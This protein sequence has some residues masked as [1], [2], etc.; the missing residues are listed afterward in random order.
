M[1]AMVGYGLAILAAGVLMGALVRVPSLVIA[2]TF[3][4]PAGIT[5]GLW[6]AVA[7]LC[8]LHIGY[9]IGAAVMR[10]EWPEEH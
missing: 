5:F 3:A 9:L 1:I 10:Q 6:Q 2:S 7:F 4:I 8:L